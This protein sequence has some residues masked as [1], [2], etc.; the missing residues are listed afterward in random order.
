MVAT[1]W[2]FVAFGT[3]A[4]PVYRN[5][6]INDFKHGHTRVTQRIAR[7]P[8][9]TLHAHT[10]LDLCVA[11]LYRELPTASQVVAIGYSDRA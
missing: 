6:P 9:H 2:R 10:H 1:P 5:G 11:I 8:I 3:H 7:L 4:A